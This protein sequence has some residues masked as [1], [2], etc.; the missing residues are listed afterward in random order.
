TAHLQL[1]AGFDHGGEVRRYL[2]LVDANNGQLDALGPRPGR[3]RV[4]PLGRVPVLGG[5]PNV[6]VLPGPVPWPVEHLQTQTDRNRGLGNGLRDRRNEPPH[7][8]VAP[9]P[10]LAP[11]VPVVVVAD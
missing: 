5:Q 9:V 10:L 2:T 8:S 7:G 6:D 4:A 11:G 3:D 1:V